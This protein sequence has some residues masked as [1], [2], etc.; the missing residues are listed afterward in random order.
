MQPPTEAQHGW[1]ARD[2]RITNRRREKAGR[3]QL[4]RNSQHPN[5]RV[6]FGNRDLLVQHPSLVGLTAFYWHL[7]AA[8]SVTMCAYHSVT[9][10]NFA[11]RRHEGGS[12]RVECP[13]RRWLGRDGI[14]ICADMARTKVEYKMNVGY[15]PCSRSSARRRR[16]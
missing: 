1:K 11:R 12:M 9:A 14:C 13:M 4:P 3:R 2:G 8:E 10:G 16:A 6:S 5:S 15:E 7:R